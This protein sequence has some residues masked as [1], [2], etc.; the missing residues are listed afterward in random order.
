MRF[1][2]PGPQLVHRWHPGLTSACYR[3]TG[4]RAETSLTSGRLPLLFEQW[5]FALRA[6]AL[7]PFGRCP[8]PFVAFIA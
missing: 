4:V 2:T 7:C 6:V 5:S 3:S 1:G 8:L